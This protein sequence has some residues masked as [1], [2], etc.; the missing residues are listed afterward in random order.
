MFKV[1][2]GLA[3][4]A[5]SDDAPAI[6][7]PPSTPDAAGT[8]SET[9]DRCVGETI[10]LAGTCVAAYPRTYNF[11]EITVTAS[12]TNGGMP[13]DPDDGSL[14]DITVSIENALV[15][16]AT[17]PVV[18]DRTSATFPGPYPVMLTGEGVLLIFASDDDDGAAQQ[19]VACALVGKQEQLAPFRTRRVSC[20]NGP[21]S[22]MITVEP[23]P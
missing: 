7:A 13:W 12:A 8:C 4:A 1:W 2:L 19:I 14:A 6:D 22:M 17:T 15:N 11:S 3:L 10:C 18:S 16:I 20:A 23:Q 21:M 5:C 9:V